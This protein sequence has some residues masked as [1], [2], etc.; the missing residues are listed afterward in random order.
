VG[1]ADAGVWK[2]DE[3]G[4]AY[5]QRRI[6]LPEG[7]HAVLGRHPGSTD[8]VVSGQWDR[9]VSSRHCVVTFCGLDRGP[10]RDS[11]DGRRSTDGEAE[12]DSF[13]EPQRGESAQHGHPPASTTARGAPATAHRGRVLVTDLSTNGTFCN[14]RR[15]PKHESVE[16]IPGDVLTFAH[17][18]VETC[19]KRGIASYTVEANAS[20]LANRSTLAPDVADPDLPAAFAARALSA[21]AKTVSSDR[22]ADTPFSRALREAFGPRVAAGIGGKPDDITTVVAVVREGP[23]APGSS[24]F[25]SRSFFTRRPDQTFDPGLSSSTNPED[26]VL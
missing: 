15:L 7:S 8:V 24:A 26:I 25:L 23:C 9:T 6:C 19:D 5:D 3:R 12:I 18:S 21:K 16:V 14:G 1:R 22:E 2:G 13:P 4:A 10:H 20:N 11:D 17:A